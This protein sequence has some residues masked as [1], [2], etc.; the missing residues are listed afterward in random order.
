MGIKRKETGLKCLPRIR[1][2]LYK[3]PNCEYKIEIFSD[4]SKVRCL[5]CGHI[6]HKNSLTPCV[7]WCISFKECT[8]SRK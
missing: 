8:N 2:G 3:C 5:N 4:E 1:V 6:I 7:N